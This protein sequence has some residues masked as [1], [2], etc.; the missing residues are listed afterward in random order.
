MASKKVQIQLDT[1]ANTT[2]AKQTV[3]GLKAVDAQAKKTSSTV[4]T[5]T[6]TA[7]YKAGQVGL[8]IQ[9][10][11]VQAQSGTSAVTI[12]AQQGSQIAGIFGP[13]GAVIGALLAVGAV[14]ANVF[15][16]MAEDAAVAGV[17]MEDMS[18]KLKTAFGKSAT[19]TIDDFNE[20]MKGSISLA[21]SLRDAE[22][23]FAAAKDT[24][25]QTNAKLIDSQ[26]KLDEA[27]INY[28]AT[29][30]Q[31]VDK[32]KAI[33]AVRNQ[34]AEATKNAQIEEA[35]QPVIQA[36]ARYEA[37]VKQRDDVL[38]EVQ[39]AERRMIELEAKQ[40]EITALTNI[41]KDRDR[42]Q[43]KSGMQKEGFQSLTTQTGQGELDGIQKQIE[44]LYK[45]IQSAPGRLEQITND[46]FAKATELDI[47]TTQ[48]QQKI[49]EINS[50]F[51]LATKAQELTTATGELTADAEKMS[52]AIDDF[53]PVTD[54]QAQ[55]KAAIT[56]ALEDGKVTAQEQQTIA[57]SLQILM[58]NLQTGQTQSIQTLQ[59][60]ISLN[61]DMAVKMSELNRETSA[62]KQQVRA[63]Q[64]IR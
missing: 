6:S 64:G 39:K 34:A 17:A 25:S 37:F 3:D 59:N 7:G 35:Q 50:K 36:Q 60:L 41:S 20:S 23:N 4:S 13:Q 49:D 33:Q 1:T 18:E 48:S 45:I 51:D 32:E 28:L 61:G 40:A 8:Q 14:A 15:F 56:Q 5:A 42:A 58:S 21:Q 24:T 16:T 2:G 38:E 54:L 22:I 57:Q 19:R 9:D 63:L 30:G 11:A 43:I 27:A 12:L 52:K 62:L 53:Q 47:A 44:N 31:I 26:L 29:T 46:S 55:A 10:I